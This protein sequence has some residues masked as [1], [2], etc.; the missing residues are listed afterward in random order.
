MPP[1]LKAFIIFLVGFW[2]AV[3]IS[4]LSISLNYNTL[5][6]YFLKQKLFVNM[7]IPE[8]WGFF[9]RNPQE[10]RLYYLVRDQ[11]GWVL[12]PNT[13]R[14]N[15]RNI[16]GL[17]RTCA[18]IN[19]IYGL[20]VLKK[21]NS[22]HWSSCTDEQFLQVQKDTVMPQQMILPTKYSNYIPKQVLILRKSIT[23]WAYRNFI[24]HTGDSIRYIKVNITFK[25]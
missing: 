7:L 19:N 18:Y 25:D 10:V 9:T 16:W 21:A 22:Q 13:K 8:G 14:A 20:K 2:I 12:D 23:P 5:S 1:K 11:Q 17:S 4:L 15:L 24:S 3:I 6:R